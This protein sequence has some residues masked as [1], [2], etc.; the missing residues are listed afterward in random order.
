MSTAPLSAWGFLLF[1]GFPMACL[2]SAIE[3]LRAAN[4]LSG[5]AVFAWSL[6]GEGAGPVRSSAQVG[7]DADMTLAD[8]RARDLDAVICLSPPDARFADPRRSNAAL[9]RLGLA[10]VTLG[11]FS[12]GVFPLRRSGALAGH[13]PS[14]HYAYESAWEAEFPEAPRSRAAIVRERG[15]ITVSGAGAVFDLMLRVIEER[16]GR[17]L[18][19]EVACW[20]QHPFVRDE[21][22]PQARPVS[23]AGGTEAALPAPVREAIRL[24]AGHVEE[25][26]A[27]RSV[28]S[29]VGLSERTL[30]RAFKAATGL[31]PLRYYRRMRLERGRQR[32]LYT[33]DAV[34]EIARGVGFASSTDFARAY[35]EA[36]GARPADER[37]RLAGLRGLA[38]AVPPKAAGAVPPE[39]TIGEGFDRRG[40]RFRAF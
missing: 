24:F 7:F 17:A 36:F 2:T 40:M 23:G 4:E 25:P 26:L 35:Q 12:G 15:R 18:M 33:A 10:G 30:E 38:G 19:T 3:P 9:R 5:R 34:A 11:G 8:P 37:R 21:A 31:G 1:P 39:E 16:E 20:F 32:V 6:L 13:A 22:A 28:A 14:V 27:I 29:R